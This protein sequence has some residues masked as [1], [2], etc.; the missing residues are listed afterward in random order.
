M[1]ILFNTH[2][3]GTVDKGN[4]PP[5]Y[6]YQSQKRYKFQELKAYWLKRIKLMR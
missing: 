2:Y 6:R 1:R 3:W 4:R 5:S